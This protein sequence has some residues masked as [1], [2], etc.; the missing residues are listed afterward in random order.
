MANGAATSSRR[1][2]RFEAV[3]SQESIDKKALA[4]LTW[5]GVPSGLSR[6]EVWQLLLG[7][8]PLTRE[9]RMEALQRKR[10]EYAE[11]RQSLYDSSPA[12]LRLGPGEGGST[13]SKDLGLADSGDRGEVALLIQIRKD[14]PRTRLRMGTLSPPADAASRSR[15]TESLVQKAEFR[16]MMERVL[17]IWALRQPASGYVQGL[18]DVIL[19]MLLV[20]LSD[21]AR[22]PVDRLPEELLTDLGDAALG[23]VEA[24]CYWCIT[25]ILS[26]ILDHYTHGQ[27]GIQRMVQRLKEIIRRIDSPLANHLESNGVDLLHTSLRWITCL[28]VRELP[29]GSCVR[30]WDTLIAES[31]QL[32]SAQ[33]RV[34]RSGDAC[35]GSPGFE[36]LLV[37]FCACF[38]AYFSSRLQQMDFEAM[39]FFFQ[40]L[41]TDNFRDSEVEVLLGEAF[42]LKSLF[43]QA[44][45]HLNGAD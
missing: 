12:L 10:Q 41:P 15:S 39:T 33:P 28:M 19:P 5:S 43:Q 45:R 22:Q 35:G 8:R 34:G 42:V 11:L 2:Q 21:R 9:R 25:K 14:L 23:E 32:V 24:D 36:A 6:C 27:P 7:Y 4:E 26:E 1:Q 44:P 30:L 38:T 29:I 40:D 18:N 20:A 37:Y 17:F 31:V 3:L 13:S 16:V